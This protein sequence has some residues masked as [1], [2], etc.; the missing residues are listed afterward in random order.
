MTDQHY[1]QKPRKKNVWHNVKATL[2][3]TG[4]PCLVCG[5]TLLVTELTPAVRPDA[6]SCLDGFLPTTTQCHSL[7]T[8]SHSIFQVLVKEIT[9]L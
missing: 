3:R 1:V 9:S 6:N 4:Y 5:L 7:Q 2:N 8:N